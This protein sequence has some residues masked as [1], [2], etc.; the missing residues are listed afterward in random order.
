MTQERQRNNG[1]RDILDEARLGESSVQ[2]EGGLRQEH[3]NPSI[4]TEMN[5]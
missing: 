5:S 4:V 1:W 2:S 3:N